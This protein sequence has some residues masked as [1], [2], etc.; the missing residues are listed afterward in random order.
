MFSYNYIS[1]EMPREL[2]EVYNDLQVDL[3]R[4]IARN[5]KN[6]VTPNATTREIQTKIDEYLPMQTKVAAVIFKDSERKSVKSNEKIFNAEASETAEALTEA[7]ADLTTAPLYEG[8]VEMIKDLNGKISINSSLKYATAYAQANYKTGVGNLK[9]IYRGLIKDGLTIYESF[10]GGATRNYSIENMVRRNIISL[11]N[12]SN[13]EIDKN[14]FK[15]S[16]A[17]FVEVSSHPT[18]RTATKYMKFP[19]ED[20]SS[21]QGK[22]YYSRDKGAVDGYEEFESTCGYGEMLG[23]CGI[24]CYHQFQMNYTGDSSATQYDK[25]EVERQYELS[26]KQ[27]A[28]ERAIRQLKQSKAVWE[29]AGETQLAK[30]IGSNIRQAT[31][32]LKDFCERHDLKYYNWRTQL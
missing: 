9:H 29:E 1:N 17:V 21:W 6:N 10:G 32:V 24:N 3:M 27:R 18:A 23:I 25:D 19:Y 20:H 8:A 12:R 7:Q 2:I 26:Q 4:I 30:Q 15:R 28:M 11:V 13:A 14:N 31:G 16:S 5:L 22:V